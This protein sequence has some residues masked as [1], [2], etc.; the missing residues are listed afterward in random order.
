MSMTINDAQKYWTRREV[1][2][3]LR[4]TERTVDSLRK[5]GA[6]RDVNVSGRSVRFKRDDVLALIAE[7]RS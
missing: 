6:L 7:R 4:L 5:R 2:E 1:A 3:Y